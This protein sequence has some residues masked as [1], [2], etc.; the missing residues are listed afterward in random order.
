MGDNK[1][2]RIKL[3]GHIRCYNE[4]VDKRNAYEHEN[5]KRFAQKTM[6]REIGHIRVISGK[7]GQEP[8]PVCKR[9]EKI[10]PE[11]SVC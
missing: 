11:K 1:Q 9:C 2:N 4:H 6:D 5:D 10:H 8:P 3:A 7:L